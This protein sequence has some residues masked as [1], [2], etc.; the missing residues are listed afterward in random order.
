MPATPTY[1][2]LTLPDGVGNAS[3]PNLHPGDGVVSAPK[4]DAQGGN[5]D[6][7]ILSS[8]FA[9]LWIVG[10]VLVGLDC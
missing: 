3:N 5:S 7:F 1:T 10:C 4:T 9:R 6:V 2:P 8:V